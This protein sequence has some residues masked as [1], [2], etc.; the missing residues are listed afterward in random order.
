MN[1]NILNRFLGILLLIMSS[2]YVTAQDRLFI[3]R[4]T[5]EV[6]GFLYKDIQSISC[7]NIDTLGMH[8]SDFVSQ[9]IQTKD[10]TYLIPLTE[11]DSISFHAPSIVYKKGVVKLDNIRKYIV[12][13]SNT[14]ILLSPSIPHNL[15][16]QEGNK[17]ATLLVDNLFPM[18]YAGE[19][20]N[21]TTNENGCVELICSPVDIEDIFDSYYRSFNGYGENSTNQA[22]ALKV[23]EQTN[24]GDFVIPINDISSSIDIELGDKININKFP[25]EIS[26]NLTAGINCSALNI[27]GY[28]LVV[29]DRGHVRHVIMEG[30]FSTEE[31]F[32]FNVSKTDTTKSKDIPFPGHFEGPIGIPFLAYFYQFGV[33]Y[34]LSC[35]ITAGIEFNQRWHLEYSYNSSQNKLP[36]FKLTP[37]GNDHSNGPICLK[38]TAAAGIYGE[39]GIKPWIVD[40]DAIGKV[41]GRFEAGIE[42]EAKGYDVNDLITAGTSTKLYDAIIEDPLVKLNFYESLSATAKLG[43]LK[44]TWTLFKGRI[45]TGLS[46]GAQVPSF[47]NVVCNRVGETENVR[48]TSQIGLNCF[49]PFKTGFALLDNSNKKIST[50]YY[51]K[52]YYKSNYTSFGVEIANV[53]KKNK[54]KAY[55]IIN[56]LG[57]DIL[58]NPSVDVKGDFDV[59][60]VGVESVGKTSATIVGYVEGKHSEH[61]MRYYS[62]STHS[63]ILLKSAGVKE[64]RY[65]ASLTGLSPHTEYQ[66]SAY[67]IVDGTTY[68]GD[69]RTF[70]TGYDEEP[71][72]TPLAIT[73]GANGI[74]A[75]NATI[76][77]EFQKIPSEATCGYSLYA[78]TSGFETGISENPLGCFEGVRSVNLKGLI[79]STTYCYSA[80]V[81][82][83]GRYYDG[84]SKYFTTKTPTGKATISSVT[85]TSAK[86]HCNYK[87]VPD[88]AICGFYL[89]DD[90]NDYGYISKEE[91]EAKNLSW[92]KTYYV[93][94]CIKLG[95]YEYSSEIETFTTLKP[96]AITGKTT[97]ITQNSAICFAS[98]KNV[99]EG[100][101]CYLCLRYTD[102]GDYTYV[103]MEAKENISQEW[104]KLTAGHKYYYWATIVYNGEEFIGEELSFETKSIP[105]ELSNFVVTKA[106]WKRNGFEFNGDT[107]KFKYNASITAKLKDATNVEDWGYAYLAPNGSHAHISL[108][109]NGN[110]FVDNRY[111]Y[112]RNEP[113]SSVILYG[114][115]KYHGMETI[116]YDDGWEYPLV[117]DEEPTITYQSAEITS[118]ENEPKYDSDGSYLFTW[119]T[120][121][122]K[123]V[124]KITGGYWIDKVQPVIYDNG[125]WSYNG[126]KTN[127]PGD[128]LYSVTT[129]M[130]YDQTSNMDW[131]TGY[132]ILLSDGTMTY[133]TNTL[134]F[135]GT[136][137]N[138]IISVGN[139]L[140]KSQKNRNKRNTNSNVNKLTK[141]TFSNLQF[142]EIEQ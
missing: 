128:G 87:Y 30:E 115:V 129:S 43:P 57:Y 132:S 133:S 122:L 124:I 70:K 109:A 55:P 95:E 112:C 22:K 26:G 79:P 52:E 125:S 99:P 131:S 54:Y 34:R 110:S 37:N 106:E 60:T 47:S 102:S 6:N 118:V 66:Y 51:D 100:A 108:A 139:S 69:I 39:V 33:F 96:E 75:T 67:I 83:N 65:S 19:V 46:L 135:G 126:G 63:W 15:I 23:Q 2:M 12:S 141:P 113:E 50:T 93:K 77:C 94:P 98:F 3:Y 127:I 16:P 74:S 130:S 134:D 18:G 36:T 73:G 4:N 68:Y 38:G 7:S 53:K 97:D 120:A 41:S 82:Y 71:A 31:A 86:I 5:G 45:G 90:E 61:G 58:C 117:Y 44:E 111:A 119:F 142:S 17:I 84:A 105:V 8:H 40:K 32:S 35:S 13:A 85:S 28:D 101:N 56:L 29:P 78:L 89:W 59:Q 27:K 14:S 81:Y 138:P 116:I 92:G 121:R 80:Y 140:N 11:I 107:Y 10:S 25:A 76:D 91:Y 21:V 48:V 104:Q 1:K 49:L 72:I 103:K 20:L 64:E 123:Y 137:E 62:P 9:E 42:L 88:G 24:S 136:P 114:Y